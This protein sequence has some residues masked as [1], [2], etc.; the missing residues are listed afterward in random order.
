[1]IR[2]RSEVPYRSRARSPPGSVKAT[3]TAKTAGGRNAHRVSSANTPFAN[4]AYPTLP[5]RNVTTHA[6]AASLG[7]AG[8]MFPLSSRVAENKRLDQPIHGADAGPGGSVTTVTGP[9]MAARSHSA[10]WV[11]VAGVDLAISGSWGLRKC[12][13]IK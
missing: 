12:S 3:E 6:S 10:A 8:L 1:M 13:K 5:T 4:H 2:A 9:T 11:N 7:R